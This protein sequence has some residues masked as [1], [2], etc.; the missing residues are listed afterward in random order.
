MA[1]PLPPIPDDPSASRRAQLLDRLQTAGRDS[2]AA[3]VMF[4][5]VV[6]ARVGLRATQE[7]AV[8]LLQRLG[9][10]TAGELA[11]HASLAPATVTALIDTLE[12]RG[13]VRRVRNPADG[14]SVLV[15]L[16]E[17]RVMAAFVPLYTAWVEEL[18]DL[19][20]GF[21][22]DQLETIAHFLTEAARR[23]RRVTA[24]LADDDGRDEG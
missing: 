15:E 21:S 6:A 7:K 18:T 17:E 12:A 5:S 22:D 24:A 11:R 16:D 4:H 2:S 1:T 13:F 10:M 23:Q 19:Y 8:D 9:P 3:T 20:R 14:R